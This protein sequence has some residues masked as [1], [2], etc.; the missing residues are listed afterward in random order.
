[1]G[2]RWPQAE[3]AIARFEAEMAQLM[4]P[5]IKIPKQPIDCS[6][7]Q[8]FEPVNYKAGKRVP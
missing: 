3:A 7:S 8:E 2:E 5:K 1:M 6:M 4:Q